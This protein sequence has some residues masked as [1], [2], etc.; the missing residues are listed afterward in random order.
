MSISS[1]NGYHRQPFIKGLRHL[2]LNL[3]L[4]VHGLS[5]L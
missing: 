1:Y 3:L 5:G 2:A 4:Q